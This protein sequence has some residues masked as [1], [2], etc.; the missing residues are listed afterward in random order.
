MLFRSVDQLS[1]E[2][3]ALLRQRPALATPPAGTP[4]GTVLELLDPLGL[5][6]ACAD[7]TLL[8]RQAQLEGRR[9]SA[10]RSLLQQLNL[11]VGDLLA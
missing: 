1:P 7:G 8:L 9:A 5:V 2:V 6:V 4:P 3:A 11:D 10:G